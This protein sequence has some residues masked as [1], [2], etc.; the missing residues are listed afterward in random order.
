MPPV[1]TRGTV[2]FV[3]RLYPFLPG[4]GHGGPSDYFGARPG[5][6]FRKPTTREQEARCTTSGPRTDRRRHPDVGSATTVRWL[7]ADGLLDELHL[8]VHPIVVGHGQRLFEDTPTHPLKLVG[9]ETFRTG[10]LDLT[11]VPDA[12]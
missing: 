6:T 12:G 10:V 4:V 11:Y 9:F 1:R 7:L 5:S 8:L 2:C 3:I